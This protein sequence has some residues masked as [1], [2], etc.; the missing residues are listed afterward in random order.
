M[1]KKDQESINSELIRNIFSNDSGFIIG[2]FRNL[3][4]QTIFTGTGTIVN[5][6]IG[7]EY[8]LFGNWKVTPKYGEQFSFTR[9]ETIIPNNPM[10]IFKYLVRSCKYVGSKIGQAL[11]DN[12][13]SETLTVLKTD[14]ARVV[15]DISGITNE[16]ALEIQE[17]LL[18]REASEK[19]MVEL[20]ALLDVQGMLKKVPETL[21]KQYGSNAPEM[22]KQD[23]YF[24]T[25]LRGVGFPLADRVALHIG[26]SRTDIKRKKAVCIHC[27]RENEQNGS[28]WILATDLLK[29]MLELIQIVGLE[30]GIQELIEQ[31]MIILD[32]S[33]IAFRYTAAQEWTIARKAAMMNNKII[34]DTDNNEQTEEAEEANSG[35]INKEMVAA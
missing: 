6:Q 13:G 32:D 26:F 17:S 8:K 27:L 4:T 5:P 34:I 2:S 3:D 19:T 25:S 24:L 28:T 20:E 7:M 23:P 1:I 30:D 12:Y 31:N 16:K 14:P 21:F 29:N 35:N 22:I 33:Y 10:G 11:I 15:K 18:T 9:F